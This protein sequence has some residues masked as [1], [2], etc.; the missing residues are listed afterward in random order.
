MKGNVWREEPGLDCY[1]CS[2]GQPHIIWSPWNHDTVQ[3]SILN[4]VDLMMPLSCFPKLLSGPTKI[5]AFCVTIPVK[6][7]SDLSLVLCL[8]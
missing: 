6:R 7:I 8:Q 3:H 1:D 4:Y 5:S 2:E